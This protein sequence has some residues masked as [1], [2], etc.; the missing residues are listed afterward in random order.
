MVFEEVELVVERENRRLATEASLM[1][2]AIDTGIAAFGK[3][4]SKVNRSFSD[5]LK[6]LSGADDPEP[7]RRNIDKGG[8]QDGSKR[9]RTPP[10]SARRR[11][12]ERQEGI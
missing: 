6:K 11:Q 8:A 9:R 2:A 5:L 10:E 7:T 12:Q 4:V 1:K 3:N